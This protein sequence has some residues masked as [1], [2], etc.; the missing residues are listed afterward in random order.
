[1]RRTCKFS[2]KFS[3]ALYLYTRS[4]KNEK[5]GSRTVTT[6]I[7][8]CKIVVHTL[9]AV[10]FRRHHSDAIGHANIV[11]MSFCLSKHL[12]QNENFMIYEH[13][14]CS[15]FQKLYIS[16]HDNIIFEI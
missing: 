11:V 5:E 3:L 13:C 15:V 8:Y 6:K 14:L 1:M 12:I 7:I 9:C 16:V 4:Y 10:S 2:I